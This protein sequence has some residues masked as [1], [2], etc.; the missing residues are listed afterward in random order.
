MSAKTAL[1]PTIN[2]ID[3]AASTFHNFR[4]FRHFWH[5]RH[6]PKE[7]LRS[8][9]YMAIFMHT[10]VRGSVLFFP[11]D[12]DGFHH[13]RCDVVDDDLIAL[14]SGVNA[15]CLIQLPVGSHTV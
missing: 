7:A 2:Q 8:K 13:I 4:H 12:F 10:F 9:I 1:L 11:V 15:I 3:R 6:S 14:G 5:F